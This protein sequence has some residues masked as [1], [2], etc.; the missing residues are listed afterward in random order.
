MTVIPK[1]MFLP[2]V[3]TTTPATPFTSNIGATT[4]LFMRG[5][6]RFTNTSGTAVTVNAYGIPSG[7][8]EGSDNNFCYRL[9]RPSAMRW[10]RR[11]RACC[12]QPHQRL[13]NMP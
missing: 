11:R 9:G 5:R 10:A 8:T 7:G 2:T 1:Q 13:S 6:I 12:R 4:A 3:L